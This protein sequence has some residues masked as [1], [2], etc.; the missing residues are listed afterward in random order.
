MDGN[1]VKAGEDKQWHV[2]GHVTCCNI[3]K[4]YSDGH[5]TLSRALKPSGVGQCHAE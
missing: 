5:A 1:P 3:L 4:K 2:R